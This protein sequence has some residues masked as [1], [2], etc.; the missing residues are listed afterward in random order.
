LGTHQEQKQLKEIQQPPTPPNKETAS[1]GALLAHLIGC[2]NFFDWE[3]SLPFL[4]LANGLGTNCGT[5][6]QD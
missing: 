3:C 6:Y 5:Q 2:K 1:F 4:A